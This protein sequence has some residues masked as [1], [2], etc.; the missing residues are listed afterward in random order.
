MMD[1]Y[2]LQSIVRRLTLINTYIFPLT[3]LPLT[4]NLL[5]VL[6][7]PE[8]L[9]TLLA[10]YNVQRKRLMLLQLYAITVTL[11]NSLGIATKKYN[12]SN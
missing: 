4:N 9:H 1:P 6:Y 3:T 11:I 7:S 2:I 10:L 5:L 8:L 12:K